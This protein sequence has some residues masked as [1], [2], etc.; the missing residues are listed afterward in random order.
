MEFFIITST[1]TLTSVVMQISHCESEGHNW[2]AF[3]WMSGWHRET[4]PGWQL[5]HL[6]RVWS[7]KGEWA[8]SDSALWWCWGRQSNRKVKEDDEKHEIRKGPLPGSDKEEKKRMRPDFPPPPQSHEHASSLHSH[9]TNANY[10]I[11][12]LDSVHL[13]LSLTADG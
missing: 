9:S 7:G 3:K 10:Q 11:C 1:V 4:H 5:T 2:E 8:L 6:T 12:W 13:K